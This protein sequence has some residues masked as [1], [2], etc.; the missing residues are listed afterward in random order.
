MSQI[1]RAFGIYYVSR[2]SHN[3]VIAQR[4]LSRKRFF[5]TYVHE[6]E[7]GAFVDTVDPMRNSD[8]RIER[9]RT[10]G[11]IDGF[12]GATS[13]FKSLEFGVTLF[14]LSCLIAT[15]TLSAI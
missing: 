15:A 9:A 5:N 14:S 1:R 8:G 4:P 10:F 11:L 7:S 2:T 12:P 3:V 6:S 13:V